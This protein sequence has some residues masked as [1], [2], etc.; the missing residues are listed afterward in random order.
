VNELERKIETTSAKLAALHAERHQAL[1]RK[2]LT[3]GFCGKRHRVSRL[4]LIQ[5]HFYIEP[6]SCTGG[7]YWKP[8][9]KQYECPSCGLR[10]RDPG[11]NDY[12]SMSVQFDR[13]IGTLARYF[14]ET[15][16]EY[17]ERR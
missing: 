7:D 2:M 13:K 3:C 6:Y 4:T 1:R 10:M 15:V 17:R 14:K 8:G 5:T 12:L 9:E 11:D 16:Q